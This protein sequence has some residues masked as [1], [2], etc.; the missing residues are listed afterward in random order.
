MNQKY[1]LS[2]IIVV[3]LLVWGSAVL[4][5]TGNIGIIHM[6][7]IGK[8]I[9]HHGMHDSDHNDD[10]GHHGMMGMMN[11]DD[12]RAEEC[13]E[14]ESHLEEGYDC[15]NYETEDYCNQSINHMDC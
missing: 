13:D 8:D 2:G 4:S 3:G 6:F 7:E 1:I 5:V 15:N 11:G 10:S 14:Y 12:H 9:G